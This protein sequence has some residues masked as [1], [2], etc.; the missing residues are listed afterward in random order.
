[1]VGLVLCRWLTTVFTTGYARFTE[2]SDIADLKSVRA[3]LDALDTSERSHRAEVIG[4]SVG[5][6]RRLDEVD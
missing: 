5:R 1:M 4:I 3:F 6:G 2:G